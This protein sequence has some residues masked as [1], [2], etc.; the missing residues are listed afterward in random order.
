MTRL[1]IEMPEHFIYVTQIQVRLGDII[2][3]LHLGNHVLISYLNEILLRFLNENGVDSIFFGETTFINTDLAITYRSESFH[4]DLLN[5]ELA[6]SELDEQG[7]DLFFRV[8]NE[9]RGKETATAK[10]GM[11]FL[12]YETRKLTTVPEQFRAIYNKYYPVV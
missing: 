10:L 3:G 4:R 7:C 11:L 8:T 2:G 6:I 1:H 12:N 5:I 9:T